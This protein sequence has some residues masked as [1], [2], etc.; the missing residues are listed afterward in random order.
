MGNNKI[1][2]V[3]GCDG[4]VRAKNLCFKHY[5]RKKKYGSVDIVKRAPTNEW[6][7][8]HCT[9]EGCTNPLTE[10]SRKG[11]CVKHYWRYSTY[12]DPQFTIRSQ[13]P[14]ACIYEG[15][16]RAVKGNGYC[17]LHYQRH[18]KNGIP[19]LV[20]NDLQNSE[21]FVYR[22]YNKMGTLIYVGITCDVGRRMSQ[23]KAQ[24]PWWGKV[25]KI[26]IRKYDTRQEAER[27]ERQSILR[28]KPKY[29]KAQYD[30]V[31]T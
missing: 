20:K 11:M 24:K 27:I 14:K 9:I 13:K 30:V 31:C 19:E 10:N 22:A 15:C 21:T 29:N 26:T 1:C 28:Y 8:G 4:E 3:D 5:Q 16:G 17:S 18:A 12:G 7:G 6:Y 23:H 25:Q 2:S